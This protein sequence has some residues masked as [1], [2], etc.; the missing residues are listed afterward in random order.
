[1]ITAPY[2]IDLARELSIDIGLDPGNNDW[3]DVTFLWTENWDVTPSVQVV[4]EQPTSYQPPVGGDFCANNWYQIDGY[5]GDPAYLTLNVQTEA[6]STNWAE[7]APDLPAAG[8]YRVEAYIPD[9]ERIYWTCLAKW[10][11]G[12]SSD[13]RYSITHANGVTNVARDQLPMADEW[14]NLGTFEFEEGEARRVD[15][16]QYH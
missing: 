7:W 13:A 10:I 2:G 12:D 3:V 15:L 8:D 14:L 6:Y 1:L 5:G 16:E 9:H 4:L 11:D